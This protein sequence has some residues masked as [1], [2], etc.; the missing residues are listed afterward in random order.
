MLGAAGILEGKRAT[1]HWAYLD[2][3]TE[4]GAEPVAE[5]F[6]IDGKVVTAAGV[7]AGIDMALALVAEATTRMSPRRSSSGSS[8]T[9]SR[10][11]TP[12]RPRRR[13]RRWSS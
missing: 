1:S 10:R 4:Y 8:T 6:V 5:R 13:I 2:Q 12:A 11:S 7:S 9:P 3:L